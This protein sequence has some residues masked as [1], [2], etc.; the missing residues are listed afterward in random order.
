MKTIFKYLLE[1]T[2]VQEIEL[3]VGGKPLCVQVQNGMP[4]IWALVDDKNPKE[5]KAVRMYATG[6]NCEESI[7]DYLGTFQL[8]SGS[9]VFHVFI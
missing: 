6:H 7:S 3:P 8:E 4:W 5:A 9:L 2:D 1:V